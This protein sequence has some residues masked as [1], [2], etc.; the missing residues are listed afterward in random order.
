MSDCILNENTIII[1]IIS[2]FVISSVLVA[3]MLRTQIQ[4]G[5]VVN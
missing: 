1:I 2:F 4:T 3:F 5:F